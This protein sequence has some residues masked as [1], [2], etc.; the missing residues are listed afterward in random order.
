MN[1]RLTVFFLLLFPMQSYSWSLDNK[2]LRCA[3]HASKILGGAITSA[4]G[5]TLF[6]KIPV[7]KKALHQADQKIQEGKKL[8]E[9]AKTELQQLSDE[10]HQG[11]QILNDQFIPTFNDWKRSL[12]YLESSKP[13][14]TYLPFVNHATKVPS[15]D[16]IDQYLQKGNTRLDKEL[17]RIQQYIDMIDQNLNQVDGNRN[18]IRHTNQML[19]TARLPLSGALFFT[20]LICMKQG[21]QG[22]YKEL[23]TVEWFKRIGSYKIKVPKVVT[24]MRQYISGLKSKI[25]RKNKPTTT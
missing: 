20:G 6:I 1:K 16:V 22:L 17:P 21:A 12:G 9:K 14:I 4:F 7:A 18:K 25:C 15:P 3:W 2:P 10:L 11:Q 13:Y 24:R 5:A 23:S 19:G 8:G